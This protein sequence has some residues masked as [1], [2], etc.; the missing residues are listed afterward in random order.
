M[1]EIAN[2]PKYGT[3]AVAYFFSFATATETSSSSEPQKLGPW[4]SQPK[5]LARTES[6]RLFEPQR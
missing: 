5:F 2:E 4:G 3:E 1:N 6:A